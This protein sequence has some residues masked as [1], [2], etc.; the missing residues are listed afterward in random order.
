MLVKHHNDMVKELQKEKS[1]LSAGEVEYEIQFAW[2]KQATF[3][4]VQS[5]T[6]TTLSQLIDIKVNK[7]KRKV[8]SIYSRKSVAF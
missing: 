1:S 5:R 7:R 3:M 4:D 8:F 6:M 2:D